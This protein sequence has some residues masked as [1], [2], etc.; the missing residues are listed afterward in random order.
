MK[1]RLFWLIFFLAACTNPVEVV[2]CEPAL[3]AP[4]PRLTDQTPWPPPPTF[5]QTQKDTRHEWVRGCGCTL[6][7]SLREPYIENA[8]RPDTGKT[9]I[10][11]PDLLMPKVSRVGR[12]GCH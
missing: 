6:F 8:A 2:V 4:A 3:D 9:V 11:T 7:L 12:P 5:T 1:C 10:G